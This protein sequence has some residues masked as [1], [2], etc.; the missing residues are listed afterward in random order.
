[1]KGSLVV[2]R[3]V[4]GI[5][6]LI[7]R[8]LRCEKERAAALTETNSILSAYI[9]YLIES[10]GCVRV[11]REAIRSNIG[12][13]RALVEASG[14]DYVIRIVRNDGC[15]E[16]QNDEEACGSDGVRN[17]EGACGGDGVRNAE[18]VGGEG[19]GESLERRLSR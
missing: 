15:G 9:A 1:M 4:K 12:K 16:V 14:G 19:N 2:R 6:R 3:M 11:S 10:R 7:L 13:Y 5:G 18:E 8:R 17:A